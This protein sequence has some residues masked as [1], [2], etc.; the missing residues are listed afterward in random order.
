MSSTPSCAW[1]ITF[2]EAYLG[3]TGEKASEAWPRIQDIDFSVHGSW[4]DDRTEYR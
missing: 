3:V 2:E 4:P 1:S